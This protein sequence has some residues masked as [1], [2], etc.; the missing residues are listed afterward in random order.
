MLS[1]PG[2]CPCA[3]MSVHIALICVYAPRSCRLHRFALRCPASCSD[4][5]VKSFFSVSPKL[6]SLQVAGGLEPKHDRLSPASKQEPAQVDS[7]LQG[8]PNNICERL[9]SL[10]L[11]GA[12]PSSFFPAAEKSACAC[13]ARLP[14]CRTSSFRS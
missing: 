10:S 11:T 4:E 9:N 13:D 2:S 3:C 14:I 12:R 6:R 7:R 1:R 8:I 5:I